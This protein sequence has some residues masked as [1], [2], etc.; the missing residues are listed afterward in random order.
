MIFCVFLSLWFSWF[1][2]INNERNLYYIV[3]YKGEDIGLINIKDIDADYKVGEGGIFIY[4]DKYLNTDLSYRAHLCLFDYC[5]ENLGLQIV[6]SHILKENK[7]AQRFAMFLGSTLE[8]GQENENNQKYSL[9]RENYLK[10]QNRLSFIRR[11]EN[12]KNN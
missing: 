9:L 8:E 6:L 2:K 1:K 5:F 11:Y 4:V 12:K 10:N 7:R 3:S